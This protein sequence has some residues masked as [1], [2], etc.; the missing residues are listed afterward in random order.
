MAVVAFVEG[1]GMALLLPLLNTIGVAGPAEGTALN[2]FLSS[3]VTWLGAGGSA[4]RVAGILMVVFALQFL[5]VV[6]QNWW[7]SWLQRDYG[8]YWQ[9]RLFDAC[10]DAEWQFFATQ[11]VGNLTN[12][13]TQETFRLAGGLLL[14]LQLAATVIATLVYFLVGLSVSWQVTTLMAG[15]AV[16]LFLSVGRLGRMNFRIGMRLGPLNSDLNVLLTEYFAGAKLIK[17]TSSEDVASRRIKQ[18]VDD[19]SVQHT[20]GTFL[21]TLVKAIFEFSAVAGLCFILV[22]GYERLAIPTG[23]MFVVLAIFVRLLPRF[24]ALQQNVHQLG[25]YLPAIDLVKNVLDAAGSMSERDRYSVAAAVTAA[26]PLSGPLHISIS[27]GGY[28]GVTTL[29]DI[30]LHLPESGLVG[31]VGES[32]AGKST[33]VNC[34]LG[35][36][37]IEIGTIMFGDADIKRMPLNVWRRQI[38]FV[39]QDPVLFHLS[40]R[41]NI[42]WGMPRAS[43][44]DVVNA[45]RQALAHDFILEQPH[46]Y[47]TVVG[48]QGM[49]LSGGQRQRL[50]IAR[51]LLRRPRLLVMDEPTNALDAVS[52]AFVL[53]TVE[54]LR[55]QICVVLVAHRLTTV[56]SADVIVV[57]EDGRVVDKGSWDELTTREGVFSNAATAQG[58]R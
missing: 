9:Q 58:I 46:G 41:D 12:L 48:D 33:L 39:P 1:L 24:N 20:W 14:L 3:G 34:L 40:I 29:R 23:S 49:R 37:E 26:P 28:R 5:L 30:E 19:I 10:I 42:A 4:Y 51:A 22:F 35:L 32:G 7:M 47:Q 57:L 13:I 36:A 43:D 6:A 45:A 15:F 55:K 25:T 18:V 8:A 38:G 27:R 11:K 44:E 50:S 16:L 56:R 17:A 2:G 31:I 52:E 54:I 53:E 21:P